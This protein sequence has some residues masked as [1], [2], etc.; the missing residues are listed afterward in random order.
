MFN[1]GQVW[2]TSDNHPNGKVRFT[3]LGNAQEK[4]SKTHKRVKSEHLSPDV[5]DS[6]PAVEK[7]VSIKFLK[8]W[9]S[10]VKNEIP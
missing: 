6:I 1:I 7:D 8:K 5:V 2:E 3:I 4:D 10:L 9:T